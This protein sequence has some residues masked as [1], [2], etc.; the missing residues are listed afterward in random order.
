ALLV[1]V[2][3]ALF[4]HFANAAMLPLVGSAMAMHSGQWATALV[5]ACIVVPQLVVAA[6]SPTV[7]DLAQSWGR[8][9]LLLIA[10]A[11]L[12][13][14]GL[15]LAL[16]TEPFAIVAMQMLDGISAAVMGILVPLILA[17]ITRGT[18]RFNLAQGVLG[19]VSGIGAAMSTLTAG[20]LTDNF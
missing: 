2:A 19:S 20:Y 3:S 15:V 11:A 7:A 14:R 12:G 1:F 13:V 4:F 8:R 10:F 5:A 18:G 17:D 9:P 6:I 16:T